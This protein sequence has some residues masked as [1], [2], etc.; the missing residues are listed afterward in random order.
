MKHLLDTNKRFFTN[1]LKTCLS[2]VKKNLTLSSKKISKLFRICCYCPDLNPKEKLIKEKTIYISNLKEINL[3][4][5]QGFCQNKSNLNR[6][7][8]QISMG[9]FLLDSGSDSN[10][11]SYS[12]FEKYNLSEKII[13][14]CEKINLRGSTGTIENCFVEW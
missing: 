4:F 11:L 5:G 14:K 6:N 9:K 1:F 10:I 8:N 13:Q 2:L 12:D 7:L 3:P